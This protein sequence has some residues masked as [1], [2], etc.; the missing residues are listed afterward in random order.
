MQTLLILL[1]RG[2][3]Y[4]ISPLIGRHCRFYPTCSAYAAE[5]IA[6]HGASRGLL[7]ALRRLGR[8]HPWH[9]GGIDPVPCARHNES[10]HHG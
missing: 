9:Q 7:L 6:T 2:Y 3:R 1:L 4:W 5:A 10:H 8:C